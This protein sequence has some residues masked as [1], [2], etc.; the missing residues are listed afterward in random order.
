MD[1]N[2]LLTVLMTA[3]V[4][5]MVVTRLKM[6]VDNK[7]ALKLNNQNN[8]F[9]KLFTG[10]P[11]I[12]VYALIS[13]IGLGGAY[14]FYLNSSTI[15]N[16]NIL[17][18]IFIVVTIMAVID[19]LKVIVR[20]TTYYND[21]GIFINKTFFRYNSIKGMKLKSSKTFTEVSLFSEEKVNVPTKAIRSLE[22]HIIRFNRSQ[23][24]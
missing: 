18:L 22:K 20:Y 17:V 3:L 2:T 1:M 10:M 11:V 9:K 23:K 14:F 21:E 19:S 12:G 8:D 15:D 24:K 16:A 7:N 13:L 6:F 4:A 5:Y